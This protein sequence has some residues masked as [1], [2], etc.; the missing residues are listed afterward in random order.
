MQP[1]Q[2]PATPLL[3][4]PVAPTGVAIKELSF[5]PD[6]ASVAAFSFDGGIR[7]WRVGDGTLT[8]SFSTLPGPAPPLGGAFFDDKTVAAQTEAGIVVFDL[9]TKS[10]VPRTLPGV[11]FIALNPARTAMVVRAGVG[12]STGAIQIVALDGRQLGARQSLPLPAGANFEV[13]QFQDKITVNADATRLLVFAEQ[14]YLYDLTSAS[15]QPQRID[16]AGAGQL[17]MAQFTKNGRSIATLHSDVATMSASFQTWDPATFSPRVKPIA[18]PHLG[19]QGVPIA[20]SPDERLLAWAD[21]APPLK[22]KMIV[23]VFDIATGELVHTLTNLLDI[24]DPGQNVI[25][26]SLSFSADGSRLAIG[27]FTQGAYVWDLRPSPPTFVRLPTAAWTVAFSGSG[28]FLMTTDFTS[29]STRFYDAATLAP[30]DEPIAGRAAVRALPNPTVPFA[31]TDNSCF[32]FIPDGLGLRPLA[33]WDVERSRELGKGTLLTCGFWFPDGRSY[34]GT[35]ATSIQIF[36]FS[37]ESWVATACQF[38]GRDLSADEWTRFGPD[39]PYH[40]TCADR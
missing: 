37:Q 16:F 9:V 12:A 31:L 25:S 19:A 1:A 24:G 30:R 36:D 26:G 15:P 22:N 27:T 34:G 35:G 29:G 14:P 11:S 21:V 38:A 8:A 5:S 18:L 4:I 20:V 13:G 6:G 39:K 40:K 7:V 32:N 28:E 2:L 3:T 10:R 33:L 23:R 17:V